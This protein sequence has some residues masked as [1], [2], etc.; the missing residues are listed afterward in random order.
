MPSLASDPG[1]L[2]LALIRQTE[3]VRLRCSGEI[4]LSNEIYLRQALDSAIDLG[5]PIVDVD[6]R[7]VHYMDS[8]A[9]AALL[10]AMR[11]LHREG[12]KLSV[13]V[14]P[15]GMRLLQLVGLDEIMNARLG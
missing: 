15:T 1:E 10:G 6:L 3:S 5:L 8:S 2:Q 12:R 4:D 7:A 9:I 14:P 13:W 11:R